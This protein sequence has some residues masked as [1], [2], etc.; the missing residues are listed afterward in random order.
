MLPTSAPN[1]NR[2]QQRATSLSYTDVTQLHSGICACIILHAFLNNNNKGHT[3][4]IDENLIR[5]QLPA[6]HARNVN[7]GSLLF[8]KNKMK[9]QAKI[10]T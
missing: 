3:R 8:S 6:Q 9:E 5:H 10:D 4:S 2:I 7:K 1:Q